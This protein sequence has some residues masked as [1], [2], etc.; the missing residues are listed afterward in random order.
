MALVFGSDPEFFAG[1]MQNNELFV[2]P[3]AYFRKFLNVPAMAPESKHPVF[4]DKMNEL[5]ILI[6]EDGVAFE[7]TIL[8]DTNWENL[9]NR[10]NLGKKILSDEILSKFPDECLP[11]VQT[12]PTIK[13]DVDRW[14]QYKKDPFFMQSMIF[15]CDRDYNALDYKTKNRVVNALKHWWRY[16]GGHIHISGSE[17]IKKE[18]IL[19]VQSCIFTGGLAAV[20]FSDAPELDKARTFL[21]GK[22]D[23]Y[24]PQEYNKLFNGIPNTDFGIEY[25]TPSNRWTNSYEHAAQL[26]KW[27]EIGIKNVLEGGLT[28]ELLNKIGKESC[29]AILECNQPLAKELLSYVESRI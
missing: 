1:Y 17:W 24:R 10:I 25:R 20:A 15:G 14:Q 8:P 4:I 6:M 29:E 28:L 5:G 7:E 13:Y 22:P 2:K 23:R 3:A 19:A 27:L 18:P 12:V 11:E 26:F 21:Y 16:G 9:F